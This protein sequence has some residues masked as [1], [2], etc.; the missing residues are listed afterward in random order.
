[1]RSVS[2]LFLVVLA[3]VVGNAT[4]F[5]PVNTPHHHLYQKTAK[6]MLAAKPTFN[7]ETNKWEAAANEDDPGYGPFGSFLRQGPPPFL[8]RLLN[9]DQYEQAVLKYMAS[10]NCSRSE[11]QGNM[12]AYFANAADWAFQKMEEKRG[13]KPVDYSKLKVQQAVLVLAWAFF[14]TPFMARIIYLGS[15]GESM[16]LDSVF[17]F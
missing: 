17:S 7:K 11:A 13:A 3:L 1:M 2:S 12:D 16:S 4:A 9:S 14:I 5:A 15:V 10:E 8:V 6:V